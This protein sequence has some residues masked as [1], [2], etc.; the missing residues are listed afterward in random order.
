MLMSVKMNKTWKNHYWCSKSIG[1]CLSNEG[2]T[3]S[4]GPA[5]KKLSRIENSSLIMYFL[6]ISHDNDV[7]DNG[8]TKCQKEKKIFPFAKL[9]FRKRHQF[10]GK[11]MHFSEFCGQKTFALLAISVIVFINEHN[12]TRDSFISTS[13]TF[14]NSAMDFMK[15]LG[16]FLNIFLK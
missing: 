5:I 3:N 16:C 1:S 13:S 7:L 4:N 11:N 9:N 8:M 12:I 14:F 10:S 15:F 2:L 6:P